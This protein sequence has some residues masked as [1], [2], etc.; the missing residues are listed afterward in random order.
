ML[1]C[2]ITALCFLSLSSSFDDYK[3]DHLLHSLERRAGILSDSDREMLTP[4]RGTLTANRKALRPTEGPSTDQILHRLQSRVGRRAKQDEIAVLKET[5]ETEA[6]D[7]KSD[8]IPTV[9]CPTSPS[10]EE[11][12][13]KGQVRHAVS[14]EPL[15]DIKIEFDHS[16]GRCI[17]ATDRFGNFKIAAEV[18][19]T[20]ASHTRPRRNI[21]FT[22]DG[23]YDTTASLV[24]VPNTERYVEPF[25]MVPKPA[26]AMVATELGDAGANDDQHLWGRLRGTLLSS[27]TGRPITMDCCQTCNAVKLHFRHGLGNQEGEPI[28]THAVA[29]N[30]KF[31]VQRLKPG[32]Y[33]MQVDAQC[34]V[35]HHMNVAVVGGRANVYDSQVVLAP[36]F[37]EYNG[38]DN[39]RF[40]LTWYARPY[41]LRMH[42]LMQHDKD[43]KTWDEVTSEQT[44]NHVANFR[45]RVYNGHG[46]KILS[47]GNGTLHRHPYADLTTRKVQ[48]WGP[49]ELVIRRLLPRLYTLYV[50]RVGDQATSLEESGAKLSV[51]HRDDLVDEIAVPSHGESMTKDFWKAMEFKGYDS[52]DPRHAA[53]FQNFKLV[54]TIVRREPPQDAYL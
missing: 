9:V 43:K 20:Q 21:R 13:V 5:G 12:V 22:K 19:S 8:P 4:A 16:Q 38:E 11:G 18:W 25:D 1:R 50:Q 47:K 7:T 48:G 27:S 45:E 15:P 6:P 42:L 26:S 54:N 37:G 31:D 34:Y 23:F 53:G 49:S 33:T 46:F 29:K 28:H 14:R 32:P 39:L 17:A 3:A 10:K 24:V 30:A 51:Y 52:S 40:V 41:D 2:Y 35:V 36:S 44:T